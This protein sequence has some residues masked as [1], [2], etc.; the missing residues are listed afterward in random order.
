MEVGHV[1]PIVLNK[2]IRIPVSWAL[3]SEFS[4][5]K[6]EISLLIRIRNSRST[7][8]EFDASYAGYLDVPYIRQMP[9]RF[10]PCQLLKSVLV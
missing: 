10:P 5:R 8:K 1:M 4:S 2:L 9:T 7:D 6:S 3:V